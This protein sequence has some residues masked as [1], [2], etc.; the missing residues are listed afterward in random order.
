MKPA[1][2]GVSSKREGQANAG[3]PVNM[4]GRVYDPVLGRFMSADPF[5]Q[6]PHNLQSYNRYSYAVNNPL[7]YTDLSGYCWGPTCW[8]QKP[9]ASLTHSTVGKVVVAIVASAYTFGAVNGLFIAGGSVTASAAAGFVAGGIMGGNLKSAVQGGVTGGIFGTV[10]YLSSPGE[11]NLSSYQKIGANAVTGGATTE[12]QGGKF[13]DG[14]L[15]SGLSESASQAYDSMVGRNADPMPGEN[16]PEQTTYRFDP[17]TGQQFPQDWPMNVVGK[18][19]PLVKTGNT[20]S[21]FWANIDKQGGAVSKALNLVPGI[22]AT[23]A[24]HDYWFNMPGHPEFNAI[25]N[26][27]LMLPAAAIT[28]SALVDGPLSVQLAVSRR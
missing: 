19:E 22:N 2:A 18:N 3:F 27:G 12:M 13:A 25:N 11:Y 10:T 24:L 1:N 20:W 15:S 23:G 8:I 7:R 5:I 28:Y 16:R 4:N 26:Y 6:A 17:D 21:N 9:L 14:L